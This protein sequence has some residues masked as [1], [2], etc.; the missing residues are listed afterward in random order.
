MEKRKIKYA[1]D[2]LQSIYHSTTVGIYKKY[3]QPAKKITD[4]ERLF[5]ILSGEFK[6]KSR[7]EGKLSDLDQIYQVFDFWPHEYDEVRDEKKI[8]E[9]L[10]NLTVTY[11]SIKDSVG[12]R[13][14]EMALSILKEFREFTN[15]LIR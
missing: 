8:N 1:I 6:I 13:D 11:T 4:K 12:L 2:E 9:V 14:E 3:T 5:L 15:G 7:V 10:G